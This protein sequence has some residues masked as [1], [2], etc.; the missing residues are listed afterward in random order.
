MS[1]NPVRVA[2]LTRL[3]THAPLT[4]KLSATSAIFHRVAP[5]SASPPFVTYHKEAGTPAYSFGTAANRIDSE[6][7]LIK[8]V[9]E[10]TNAA[11]AEEIAELIRARMDDA[12][13]TITGHALLIC[14]RVSDTDYGEET[15]GTQYHHVGSSYRLMT[16]PSS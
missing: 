6:L 5:G 3:S 12:P 10:G 15:D 7:W 14:R 9:C 2:V 13:L 1:A 4:S 16:H 8:A 11:A